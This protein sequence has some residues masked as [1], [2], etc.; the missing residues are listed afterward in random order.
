MRYVVLSLLL[1]GCHAS[2]SAA[3]PAGLILQV[4]LAPPSQMGEVAIASITMQ[5]GRVTAVSD[6]SSDDTR[7]T[8][9]GVTLSMG[10]HVTLSLSSAPPGLYSA[11]DA[12]LGGQGGAGLDVEAVWR[13][14]RVH[15]TIA[16]LPFDV[17]CRDPV[18]LDPGQRVQLALRADPSAWFAGIDLSR[19][20]G[21]VDD[22]G[23][24]I[25]EDDNPALANV[26]DANVL[27]SFS[28]SCL[29]H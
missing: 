4:T 10:D 20:T 27:S 15:A 29:A 1:L 17:E 7:A 14:G 13:A 28:L 12:L 9:D 22:N 25:S 23:I 21:D 11:A 5:L 3:P 18:R 16:S 2:P 6:R 26:F 19:V 8:A 24:N